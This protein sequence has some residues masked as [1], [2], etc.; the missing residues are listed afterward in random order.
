M[1]LRLLLNVIII[2]RRVSLEGRII[3]RLRDRFL[4]LDLLSIRGLAVLLLRL[5]RYQYSHSQD[6]LVDDRVCTASEQCI[7]SY[8][9]YRG[10]L[11]DDAV[12]VDSC[13]TEAVRHVVTVRL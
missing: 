3:Y 5:D 11:G 12:E 6:D 1:R 4:G 2:R 13:V 9:R 8:L 7:I 10:R